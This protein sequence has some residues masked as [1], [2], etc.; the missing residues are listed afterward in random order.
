M[1]AVLVV[2]VVPM[3]NLETLN[4]QLEVRCASHIVERQ[5]KAPGA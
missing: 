5:A 1:L 3:R 4:E 2:V